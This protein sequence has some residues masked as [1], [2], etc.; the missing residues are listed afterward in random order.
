LARTPQS[1]EKRQ[2]ERRKQQK[3][4]DKFERRMVRADEKKVRK[5]NGGVLPGEPP[6][7]PDLGQQAYDEMDQFDRAR[8]EDTIG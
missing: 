3:R 1:F 6:G 5:E 4:D 8:E 2:R 7:G